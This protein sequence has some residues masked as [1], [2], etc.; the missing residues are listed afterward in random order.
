MINPL[1]ANTHHCKKESVLNN[2]G[3]LSCWD[4]RIYGCI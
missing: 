3:E 2:N 1:I 4:I